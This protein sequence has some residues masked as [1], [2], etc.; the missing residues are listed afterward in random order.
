M[1]MTGADYDK[2]EQRFT[3]SCRLL[4]AIAVV[5]IA[6]GV[7]EG[8]NAGLIIGAFGVVFL[9]LG[10]VAG[11]QGLLALKIGIGL[12]AMDMLLGIAVFFQQ[13][14]VGAQFIISVP[15]KLVLLGGLIGGL[16]AGL[17]LREERDRIDDLTE[18]SF[19]VSTLHLSQESRKPDVISASVADASERSNGFAE[20]SPRPE[21]LSSGVAERLRQL[22]R[23][24]TEGLITLEEFEYKKKELLER[25]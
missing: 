11:Q 2:L 14:Q 15:V 10:L 9:F 12:F 18:S 4:F 3:G 5:N 8:G 23:L 17:K 20:S 21:D 25:L 24:K 13:P 22:G 16:R 19:A 6:L 1:N 7:L